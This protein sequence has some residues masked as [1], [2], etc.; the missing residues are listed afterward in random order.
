MV[1]RLA[2]ECLVGTGQA[3]LALAVACSNE[4]VKAAAY[5]LDFGCGF[6]L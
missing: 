2:P 3:R 6:L 1:N 4:G 5:L